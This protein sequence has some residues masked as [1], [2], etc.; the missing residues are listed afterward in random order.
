MVWSGP[1]SFN[2]SPSVKVFSD[3]ADEEVVV[4]PEVDKNFARVLVDDAEAPDCA[5]VQRLVEDRL[6]VRRY[7]GTALVVILQPPDAPNAAAIRTSNAKVKPRPGLVID[8]SQ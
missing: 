2:S 3:G 5:V 8:P 7:F 4:R 1:T 6:N